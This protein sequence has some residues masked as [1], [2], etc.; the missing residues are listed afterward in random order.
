MKT[1]IIHTLI[2]ILALAVGSGFA[3][4][5]PQQGVRAQ[6]VSSAS[7]VESAIVK[8]LQMSIKAE[9]ES[10]KPGEPIVLKVSVKNTTPL[11]LYLPDTAHPEWDYKFVVKNERGEDVPLTIEGKRLVEDVAILRKTGVEMKPGAEVKAE[12][13]LNKLFAMTTPGLYTLT[14]RHGA[15]ENANRVSTTITSNT[16]RV[17]VTI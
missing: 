9:R 17:R 3:D 8:G 14:V 12:F 1:A 16:I 5:P 15:W 13:R 10:F 4:E 2:T 11:V 6:R 7:D